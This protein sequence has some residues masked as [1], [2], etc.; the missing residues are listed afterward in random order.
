MRAGAPTGGLLNF[1]HRGEGG[2][3]DLGYGI[4][5]ARLIGHDRPF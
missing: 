3:F 2:L 5:P 1:M 4:A